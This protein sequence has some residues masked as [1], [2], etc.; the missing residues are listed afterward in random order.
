MLA[1]LPHLASGLLTSG[2]QYSLTRPALRHS[3]VVLAYDADEELDAADTTSSWDEE[4]AGEAAWRASMAASASASDEDASAG[5]WAGVPPAL[6]QLAEKAKTSEAST[7]SSTAG[8]A[9]PGLDNN[10]VLRALNVVISNLARLEEKVDV[11]TAV[12]R[13]EQKVD[14]L[15][16]SLLE[17]RVAPL[18]SVAP[19]APGPSPPVKKIAPTVA[20]RAAARIAP[21]SAPKT[22]FAQDW[23]GDR[24]DE[25]DDNEWDGNVNE[26]SY[27][28]VDEETANLP[29]WREVRARKG[30]S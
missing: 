8:E 24:G 23:D 4:V 2:L 18:A 7:A 28:D 6:R 3:A 25:D 21:F 27:F 19:A 26:E 20:E 1:L 17:Q 5:A 29:D 22:M 15:S 30:L 13:L 9:A 14:S 16:S 10:E 12:T 11:L